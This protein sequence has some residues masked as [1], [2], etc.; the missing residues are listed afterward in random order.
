M[1]N[2]SITPEG[3]KV[4]NDNKIKIYACRFLILLCVGYSIFTG[5]IICY[6][7]SS[8]YFSGLPSFLNKSIAIV[9]V[10]LIEY[11]GFA[12]ALSA[13]ND[14]LSGRYKEDLLGFRFTLIL[15][16]LCYCASGSFSYFGTPTVQRNIGDPLVVESTYNIDS[17]LNNNKKEIYL[18]YSSD[19]TLIKDRYKSQLTVVRKK[20]NDKIT[21]QEKELEKYKTN[22][23][24][25]VKWSQSWITK[26]NKILIR[27][28]TTLADKETKLLE[29]ESD[30]LAVLLNNRVFDLN[31]K[32]NEHKSSKDAILIS[33]NNKKNK[34]ESESKGWVYMMRFFVFISIPVL[35]FNLFVL[36]RIYHRAGY[37]S[38][39]DLDDSFFR[40]NI[41]SR[42]VNLLYDHVSIRLSNKID[43]L[44][45][46]LPKPVYEPN[47]KIVNIR[48]DII[49]LKEPNIK[50]SSIDLIK[51]NPISQNLKSPNKTIEATIPIAPTPS[52]ENVNDSVIAVSNVNDENAKKV[53]NVISVNDENQGINKK[54]PNV[55]IN[56]NSVNARN[57]NVTDINYTL[58]NQSNNVS[59]VSNSAIAVSNVN[60]PI[61]ERKTQRYTIADR[62]RDA[63]AANKAK[64]IAKNPVAKQKPQTVIIEKK[65]INEGEPVVF[66]H[67]NVKRTL[68]GVKGQLQA[69]FLRRFSKSQGREL[70]F[71]KNV[72]LWVSFYGDLLKQ[73]PES[74][75]ASVI[76]W[77]VSD[78]D[79][80]KLKWNKIEGE[81]IDFESEKKW[82]V[83]EV[84]KMLKNIK[85]NVE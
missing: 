14:Y 65:I 49:T 85:Q 44:E 43:R 6:N 67:K 11:G 50:V 28:K 52:V 39:R 20:Y 68:T 37:V 66:D 54:S 3:F 61:I 25:K 16:F 51:K 45:G 9:V 33:N 29:S 79:K 30:E 8:T 74:K 75:Q 7:F 35:I 71:K 13:V 47:E 15:S 80:R 4:L 40:E 46:D 69:V 32:S 78:I 48:R 77:F 34:H 1:R 42:V 55:R 81:K 53:N 76:D 70:T 38:G 2:N 72:N 24:N 27:L 18:N 56:D 63:R 73:M 82:V 31:E 23:R 17:L 19:S 83:G 64:E 60:E 10:F 58:A 12:F 84:S 62:E 22:L 36:N 26:T 41:L 5:F 57:P 21:F 59:T